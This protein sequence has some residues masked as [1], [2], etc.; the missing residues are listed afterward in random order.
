MSVWFLSQNGRWPLFPLSSER[1][2]H[3]CVVF[4]TKWQMALIPPVVLSPPGPCPTPAPS[5]ACPRPPPR[6]RPPQPGMRP[7]GKGHACPAGLR[8]LLRQSVP[9]SDAGAAERVAGEATRARERACC[10]G[11]RGQAAGHLRSSIV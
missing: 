8:K 4:I 2:T 5:A 6:P 11:C 3:E 10:S 9:P 1:R 7:H